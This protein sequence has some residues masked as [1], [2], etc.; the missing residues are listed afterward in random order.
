MFI[1]QFAAQLSDSSPQ[2]SHPHLNQI[3][4]AVVRLMNGRFEPVPESDLGSFAHSDEKEVKQ[5]YTVDFA[6]RCI[7]GITNH[8]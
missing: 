7:E 6:R 8:I 5:S 2:L 1:A 4:E 3:S